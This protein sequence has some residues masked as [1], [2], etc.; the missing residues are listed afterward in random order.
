MNLYELPNDY[1]I[2]YINGF[3]TDAEILQESYVTLL[4]D[5]IWFW[6]THKGCVWLGGVK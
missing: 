6:H 1:K 2:I 3:I 5:V 4:L